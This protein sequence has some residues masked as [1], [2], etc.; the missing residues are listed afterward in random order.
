V[1]LDEL[2]EDK[3][4]L[5]LRECE[6]LEDDSVL[7]LELEDDSVD[8]LEELESDSSSS[9]M[10]EDELEELSVLLLLLFVLVLELLE[11]EELILLG[12]L[13]EERE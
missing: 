12:E 3:L 1:L 4:L 13:L 10:L 5:E 2:D 8:V 11:R 7:E 9:P 6:E